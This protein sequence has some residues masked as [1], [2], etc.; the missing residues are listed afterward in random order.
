MIDR[1][2]APPT[3]TTAP[4]VSSAKSSSEPALSRLSME[5]RRNRFDDGGGVMLLLLAGSRT[6]RRQSERE[7]E[8]RLDCCA[9][10][11]LSLN[12]CAVVAS[13]YSFGREAQ[14]DFCVFCVSTS[15]DLATFAEARVDDRRARTYT[16]SIC[17]TP[18]ARTNDQR[19]L[20]LGHHL[21]LCAE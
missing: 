15:R 13:T 3:R 21:H 7:R 16:P 1:S 9:I 18:I 8:E 10:K 20:A 11:K 14:P 2:V 12:F 5:T 17:T 4:S 19:D 6:R